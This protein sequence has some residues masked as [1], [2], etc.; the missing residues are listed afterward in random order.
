MV[1]RQ[2]SHRAPVP[3]K[4]SG[5]RPR[6]ERHVRARRPLGLAYPSAGSDAHCDGRP[7]LRATFGRS[8]RS[9]SSRGCGLVFAGREALAR[10]HVRQRDDAHRHPG[11]TRRQGRQLDGESR[12]RTLPA[13]SVCEGGRS[14]MTALDG[15]ENFYVIVGSS[16]GALIGLQFVVITLIAARPITRGTAQAGGAFATPSVVHFAVVLLLSAIVSAPWGEI[17]IVAG[18]W[19]FVGVER[20]ARDALRARGTR[21]GLQQGA[22]GGQTIGLGGERGSKGPG[23]NPAWGGPEGGVNLAG[24]TRVPVDDVLSKAGDLSGKVLI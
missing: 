14:I 13:N 8:R 16:A 21:R 9:D 24:G 4:R 17:T 19:G 20:Q 5:A 11:G 2:G 12:R 22:W 7:R 15:W 18:L 6:C 3:G 23:G 10:R 1:H